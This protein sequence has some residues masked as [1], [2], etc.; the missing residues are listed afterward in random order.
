MKTF[1]T[2]SDIEFLSI[3][4]FDGKLFHEISPS[5][6]T[7]G[8]KI[9]RA[10][11]NGKTFYLAKS[12]LI[13]DVLG[14]IALNITSTTVQRRY[15]FI[16]IKFDGVVVDQL[17]YNFASQGVVAS[18]PG[19]MAQ[20]DHKFN[21]SVIGKS[22]VGNGIKVLEVE[23]ISVLGTYVCGLEGFEEDTGTSPKIT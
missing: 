6:T 3:K 14:N 17:Y 11:P 9:T 23:V 2:L 15:C 19:G 21:S 1:R 4:E 18:D 20:S 8:V 16:D 10:I 22:F 12:T 5:F 13:S 7:T